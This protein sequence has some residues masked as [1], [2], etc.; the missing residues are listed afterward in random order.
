MQAKVHVKVFLQLTLKMIRGL[1]IIREVSRGPRLLSV[2]CFACSQAAAL[3]GIVTDLQL[4][5]FSLRKAETAL[6]GLLRQVPHLQ[7]SMLALTTFITVYACYLCRS[8]IFAGPCVG[9]HDC[10][11][12]A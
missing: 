8:K 9:F 5:V 2:I 10:I 3:A 4:E 7:G 1:K 6:E 12:W 11:G